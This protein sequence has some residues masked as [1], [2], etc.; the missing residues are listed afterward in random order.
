MQ[1]ELD[2]R[3][4]S[5]EGVSEHEGESSASAI[6]KTYVPHSFQDLLCGVMDPVPAGPLVL[7]EYLERIFQ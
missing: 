7:M 2:L 4:V 3:F 6:I 5:G 1:G